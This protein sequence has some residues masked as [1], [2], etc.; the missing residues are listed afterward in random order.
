[1]LGGI[2]TIGQSFSPYWFIRIMNCITFLYLIELHQL[3]YNLQVSLRLPFQRNLPVSYLVKYILKY[4][5]ASP[6]GCYLPSRKWVLAL[7]RLHRQKLVEKSVGRRSNP[8]AL[9]AT[10]GRYKKKSENCDVNVAMVVR[11]NFLA[12]W[13]QAHGTAQNT[14]AHERGETWCLNKQKEN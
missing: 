10:G 11:H 7:R 9:L 13:R 2:K 8:C 3:P 4:A 5:T 1:M 12:S 14:Y 6:R